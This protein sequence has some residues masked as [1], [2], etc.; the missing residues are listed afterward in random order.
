MQGDDKKGCC[1]MSSADLMW[2]MQLLVAV[3][4]VPSLGLIIASIIPMEGFAQV[5]VFIVACWA[6]TFLGMKLMQRSK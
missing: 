5:A 3:L 1:G 4:A 6:C 2:W